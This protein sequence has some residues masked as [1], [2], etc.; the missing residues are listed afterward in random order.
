M[1]THTHVGCTLSVHQSSKTQPDRMIDH[2]SSFDNNAPTIKP[3]SV[4]TKIIS[5]IN[6]LSLARSRIDSSVGIPPH[7][8]T[9]LYNT[10]KPDSRQMISHSNY[11]DDKS[12][13]IKPTNVLSKIISR[14]NYMSLPRSRIDSSFGIPP[15]IFI[16]WY[17]TTKPDRWYRIRI[18]LMINFRW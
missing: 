18:A 6:Y 17:N 14:I 11:F 10:T 16:N 2:S 13:T 1:D 9:N 15:H 4:L 5:R 3:T 8:F 12:R 7:I